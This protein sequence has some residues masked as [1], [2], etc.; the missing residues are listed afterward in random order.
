MAYYPKVLR[1]GEAVHHLGA[2]HWVIYAGAVWLA[3]FGALLF[4]A[5]A[6][7]PPTPADF[8]LIIAGGI[9]VALAI[10]QGAMTWL[11]R[12]T[13]EMVVTDLRVIYKVG[14]VRRR[15]V[16]M[17]ISKIETVDVDQSILGRL[18]GYGTVLIRGT[19]AGFEPLRRVADPV[20]LRNAILV[21]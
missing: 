19:G 10:W 9:A 16:E 4:I 1:P 14:L 11:R 13:T 21:G 6:V 20:A 12:K 2:L 18:L 15:T 17:N 7:V 5:D 3:V 8:L